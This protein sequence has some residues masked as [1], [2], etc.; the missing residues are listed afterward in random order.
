MFL[1]VSSLAVFCDSSLIPV[2]LRCEPK[3]ASHSCCHR[4]THHYGLY[5][6]GDSIS[7]A[8]FFSRYLVTAVQ[9]VTDKSGTWNI[10]EGSNGQW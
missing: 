2:Q 5:A 9:K 7:F 10:Q 4:T 1:K 8:L 3:D 6:T